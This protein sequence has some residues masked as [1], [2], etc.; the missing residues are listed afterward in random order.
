MYDHTLL[1]TAD[2]IFRA[3]FSYVVFIRH[4]P[5][6]IKYDDTYV[7]TIDTTKYFKSFIGH[8]T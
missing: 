5:F 3:V 6:W 4:P 7:Y 2:T 8:Y 1:L